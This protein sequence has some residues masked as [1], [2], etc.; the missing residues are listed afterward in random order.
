[1]VGENRAALVALPPHTALWRRRPPLQGHRLYSLPPDRP[2]GTPRGALGASRGN[3]AGGEPID[4]LLVRGRDLLARAGAG[5]L[6]GFA[7]DAVR[8]LAR[9]DAHGDRDVVIGSELRR[10]GDD[11]LGIEHPLG[12]LAQDDDIYVLVDGWNRA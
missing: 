10:P 5:D 9:D 12:E 8:S 6:E 11:R 1:L 7:R 3:L 2:A 4:W